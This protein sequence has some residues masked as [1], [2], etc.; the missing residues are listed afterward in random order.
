ME[1]DGSLYYNNMKDISPELH[2]CLQTHLREIPATGSLK[3]YYT[4][5][6]QL[7]SIT[8]QV[9]LMNN[10][11]RYL[12]YCVQPPGAAVAEQRRVRISFL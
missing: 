7:Y 11:Q 4:E 12:F 6:S 10:V 5:R 3:F 2:R 8:A 1:P 9:L